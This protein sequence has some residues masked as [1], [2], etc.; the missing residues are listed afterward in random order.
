MCVAKHNVCRAHRIKRAVQVL[1]L[2]TILVNGNLTPDRQQGAVFMGFLSNTLL[3]HPLN[4]VLM[5][6]YPFY[7][8]VSVACL[9]FLELEKTQNNLLSR[10][11]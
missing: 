8:G 3:D 9:Y 1:I 10:L 2:K 5:F 7:G 4:S 11:L 6:I